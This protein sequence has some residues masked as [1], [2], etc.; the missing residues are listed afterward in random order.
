[1]MCLI[2]STASSMRTL[3]FNSTFVATLSAPNYRSFFFL[4]AQLLRCTQIYSKRPII[5]NGGSIH[6][7]LDMLHVP[8]ASYCLCIELLLCCMRNKLAMG[9]ICLNKN[10]ALANSCGYHFQ[11][12]ITVHLN[13]SHQ[14][15]ACLFNFLVHYTSQIESCMLHLSGFSE[16]LAQILLEMLPISLLVF[17]HCIFHTS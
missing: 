16:G 17:L 14:S 13:T 3:I 10:R 5:W 15:I 9:Q 12:F 1:M 8:S 2:Q 11:G 6:V 7:Q 4:G